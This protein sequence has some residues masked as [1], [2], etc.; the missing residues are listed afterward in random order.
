[1]RA[2]PAID[3]LDGKVVR[4]RQGKESTAEFY[5]YDPLRSAEGFFE[6]GATLVHIVDLNAALHDDLEKNRSIVE[7]LLATLG[8]NHSLQLAGGIRS[9]ATADKLLSRGAKRIVLSSLAYKDLDSALQILTDYGEERVVLALDYDGQKKVRTGGWKNQ[10]N[11]KVGVAL[12]RFSGLG[13]T[14][15]LLTS[16]KQDGML[17]GPDYETLSKLKAGVGRSKKLI[18]SGGVSSTED[19]EKLERM[20]IEEAIIGKAIYEHKISD[21]NSVFRRFG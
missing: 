4:V 9:R 19:L 6:N 12:E 21:L 11:E 15:F 1:M 10:N 5:S 14:T 2:I 18:V 16:V 3:I 20:G 7:G 17:E 8:S 13:F